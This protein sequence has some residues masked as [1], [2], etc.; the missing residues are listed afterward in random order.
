MTKDNRLYG[1]C[2]DVGKAAKQNPDIDFIIYHSGYDIK[3]KDGPFEP[4]D[5]KIGVDSLIQSLIEN[6]VPPNSNVYAELGTTWRYLMRDP[7]EAA[8]VMGKLLRY[9]GEDRI[10]WGTDSIW[11]GS[12]QDQIQ[13]FRTFQIAPEFR[14]RFG[15]PEITPA[16]RAK[17]FG[18]NAAGPYQLSQAEVQRQLGGDTVAR[19]RDNYQNAPDPSFLTY[20]PKNR[21][22]LL[23]L[24]AWS[25]DAPT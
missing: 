17:I 23:N 4:G 13:A 12:P 1:G 14:E 7:E 21:R 2:R 18:L 16:I 8:H 22:E 3:Q 6:D 9:V 19:A 24:M 5:H 15:Y 25:G 10:V 11:Y 20:G